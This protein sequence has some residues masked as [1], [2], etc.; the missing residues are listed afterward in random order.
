MNTFAGRERSIE[1]DTG[2]PYTTISMDPQDNIV[3][4]APGAWVVWQNDPLADGATTAIV[5]L[6]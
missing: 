4:R 2:G 5:G 3:V 1:V 6:R